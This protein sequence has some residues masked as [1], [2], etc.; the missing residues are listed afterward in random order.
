[1]DIQKLWRTAL[2]EIELLVSKP[3]FQTQFS[4]SE[5]V[6]LERGVATVGFPNAMIKNLVEVR[7]Y[8]LIKSILDQH[9]GQNVS[10]VLVV[11]PHKKVL[12]QKDAGPLFEQPKE[13][14]KEELDQTA[15]RLHV[16]PEHTFESFAVSTSNQIAYAAATAVAKTPGAAYNPLFFYGGVGVGKTHLMH[17]VANQLLKERRG[18]KIVYCMGEEFLNEIVEAIQTK[19]ARQFKQKYR[20]ADLLL[21]DDVQFIAGKQTA[22]EEFFH[23][24]NAVHRDGGQI[25]L[26]SDRAPEEISR[27]EDRLRSRFEGG[28]TVDISAPDFELRT[29]IVNIKASALNIGLTPEASRIISAN[30]TDTR[31]IE[32]FLKRITTEVSARPG[33]ILTPEFVSS[34]LGAKAKN[35]SA[36]KAPDQKRKNQVTAQEVLNAVASYFQIKP[37]ALKGP[38]RDRP[39]ARPRQVVMYLCKT[40]LGMTLEDVGGLLGGRD[41]TTIMHGADLITNE[42]ST[43]VRLRDSVEGIKKFLWG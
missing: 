7:H 14:T 6:S 27:L 17:A 10:L 12:S 35:N 32:G 13:T 39:I 19:T 1:M 40:E 21:V 11:A 37:T 9:T 33:T 18:V 26:T 22:Q 25:I 36:E 15:R 30:L 20:S 16:R 8:S 23:T 24:F 3:V 41:H 31:S 34:L 42:I 4:Q 2:V 43:N 29:A 38:K 28:L 5:L